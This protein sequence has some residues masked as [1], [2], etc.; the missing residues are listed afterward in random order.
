M[1]RLAKPHISEEAIKKVAEILRSGNLVQGQYVREFEAA[2]E[3]YLGVEHAVVVSSGTAAL[4]LS[5]IAADIGPG[6]E[7]IVPAFTFPATANVVEMVGATPILVDITLDDFCIDITKIEEAISPRTKAIIPVHEFGQS[8]DMAPIMELAEKYMLR[9]I[10]DAACALGTEYRSKKA[11]TIGDL[12]CFSF[13]P[14]KAITTGEGG[15]VVTDHPDFAEKVRSYRNHGI[16][17]RNGKINFK[18]AGL[19]YRMTDFQAVLGLTQLSEMDSLIGQRIQ[20]ARLYDEQLE[21]V[22]WISTPARIDDRK[23]V[24]QTY[25]V[26]I[27]SFVDRDGLINSLK[28]KNIE[29]NIG[30][31][32]LHMIEYYRNK[33][34]F[35]SDRFINARKAGENGLALPI[36]NHLD[37]NDC[38]V[39][40][41]SLSPDTNNEF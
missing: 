5:L 29:S 19:N 11:G 27:D 4:H 38:I 39:I 16:S 9:V 6:A 13:H 30:A 37:S 40:A 15:V 7:V 28:F 34:N 33:Y 35:A 14:R 24:Y 26:I 8:A 10:E 31:S 36:G 2:L 1:I 12:G 23:Q 41:N 18:Y 25:H 21:N 20:M 17:V 32:A 3:K 22:D